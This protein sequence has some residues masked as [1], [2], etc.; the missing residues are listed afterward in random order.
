[1]SDGLEYHLSYMASAK[2]E[3]NKWNNVGNISNAV[4]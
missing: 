3:T 4:K 1:M 2:S